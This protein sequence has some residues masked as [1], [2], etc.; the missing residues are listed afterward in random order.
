M[1]LFLFSGTAN[2]A[3]GLTPSTEKARQFSLEVEPGKEMPDSAIVSNLT[4][5]PIKVKLYAADGTQS[6][7]GTF[8]LTTLSNEQRHIG[9]WVT[10][11]DA[12]ITL[13]PHENRTLGFI[14]KV[15]EQTTPGVYAGGIAAEV[16]AAANGKQTQGSAVSIS[17]RIVV[18]LF[19]T[20]PGEKINKYSWDNFTYDSAPNEN[21]RFNLTFKNEGNTVI[22][23]EQ[24]I[25]ISG[26]PGGSYEIN[27]PEGTLLQGSQVEI[28]AK[29]DSEPFFGLYKA[30]ATVNFS[31]LDVIT[32][33]KIST[34]TVSKELSIYIPLKTETAEGKLL[35][36]VALAL[37]AILIVVIAYFL[38]RFLYLRKCTPYVVREGDSL[39]GI[40]EQ[41]GVNWKKI[42]KINKLKAPYNVK[43]G[44]KI[45]ASLP[46]KKK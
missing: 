18:K 8:A 29:W 31:E 3:I 35:I 22:V 14:V 40:A 33:K 16:T 23:V 26:F 7:L 46:K 25:N 4:D 15:P 41:C 27:L 28:P 2:A 9:K 5:Q 20:V 32:D 42:A 34:Q 13:E 43:P 36:A 45:L 1:T 6:N 39:T 24:K 38:N 21:G 11:K 17:S 37:L 44:Q 10:F 19:V 30:T 12:E